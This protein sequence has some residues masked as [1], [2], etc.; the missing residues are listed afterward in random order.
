MIQDARGWDL[1]GN[2]D[3]YSSVY[4]KGK[5]KMSVGNSCVHKKFKAF[6]VCLGSDV[7]KDTTL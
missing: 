7:F 1:V 6:H 3:I 5:R 4:K 2:W